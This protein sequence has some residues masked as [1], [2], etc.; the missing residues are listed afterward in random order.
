MGPAVISAIPDVFGLGMF[1]SLSREDINE[2]SQ[3]IGVQMLL[4]TAQTLVKGELAAEQSASDQYS[5]QPVTHWKSG[6]GIGQ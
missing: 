1:I 5:K 2:L 4:R 6:M 3:D